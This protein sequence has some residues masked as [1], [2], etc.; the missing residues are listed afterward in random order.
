MF[1]VENDELYIE[2]QE[3]KVAFSW[4]LELSPLECQ[5]LFQFIANE[6][7]LDMA[8]GSKK[9]HLRGEASLLNPPSLSGQLVFYP[10]SFLPWH[11]GHNSCLRNLPQF[12]EGIECHVVIIPDLNPWKKNEGK[13]TWEQLRRIVLELRKI[14]ALFKG[15]LSLFLG[16]LAKDVGNPTVDWL[17]GIPCAS[18]WLLMGEDTFLDLHKWKDYKTLI[19]GL[20]GIYIC[21]RAEDESAI[22]EQKRSLR[23]PKFVH[24]PHHAFER[25]SSTQI[26]GE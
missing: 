1:I 16:F 19:S 2:R 11:D 24:L 23:G 8:S 21:P 25:V 4:D 20:E 3:G 22:E 17:P 7:P 18:K 9:I 6:L 15:N 14:E 12:I 5:G 26:R 10:G 13:G